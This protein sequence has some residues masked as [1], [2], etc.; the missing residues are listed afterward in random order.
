M[1]NKVHIVLSYF[2]IISILIILL[3]RS[4]YKEEEN[5]NILNNYNNMQGL[6]RVLFYENQYERNDNN[7]VQNSYLDIV[8]ENL[9]ELLQNS[10]TKIKKLSRKEYNVLKNEN[11]E[12]QDNRKFFNYDYKIDSNNNL[13]TQPPMN[14]P[15]PVLIQKKNMKNSL[16]LTSTIN[17]T[18]DVD[19]DITRISSDSNLS[20]D[21]MFSSI[22]TNSLIEDNMK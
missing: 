7:K 21:D 6:N 8:K 5:T 15:T 9:N 20:N 4:L 22:I 2:G 10:I 14:S 16:D 3:Y 19:V 18:N 12:L 11:I 13:Y 1:I 17:T